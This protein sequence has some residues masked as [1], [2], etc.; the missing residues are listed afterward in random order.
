MAEVTSSAALE[1]GRWNNVTVAWGPTGAAIV[2]DGKMDS[3]KANASP[4]SAPD[5]FFGIGKI[6]G[7]TSDAS[8]CKG[9]IRIYG[10]VPPPEMDKPKKK[11]EK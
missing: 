2:I 11:S 5:G 8:F 4:D 10:L 7:P 3:I 9:K 6:Y 1:P